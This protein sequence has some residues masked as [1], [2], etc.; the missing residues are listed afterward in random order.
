MENGREKALLELVTTTG[1]GPEIIEILYEFTN[2]DKEGIKKI[3]SSLHKNIMLVKANFDSPTIEKSGFF[4]FAYDVSRHEMLEKGFFAFR[5][6]QK[7]DLTQS[8]DEIRK[9][10]FEMKKEAKFNSRMWN[11][12]EREFNREGFLKELKRLIV[13]Y[14]DTM[15]F[16]RL[17]ETLLG[18]VLA[19]VFYHKNFSLGLQIEMLDPLLFFKPM[20]R[21]EES[22]KKEEKKQ[23]EREESKENENVIVTSKVYPVLDPINGKLVRDILSDEKVLFELRD[24]REAAS[25]IAEL[26]QK[27]YSGVLIGEIQSYSVLDE[28]TYKLN[29]FFAPGIRGECIV[30]NTVMLKL[31]EISEYERNSEAL[32]ENRNF[33]RVSYKSFITGI[34]IIIF[35]ILFFLFL[36]Q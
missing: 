15:K 7:L 35:I 24:E 33:I 8:W 3:L 23:F 18:K 2:G 29:V 27:K 25:Y 10:I 31:V 20:E 9:M 13:K 11:L 4:Y 6:F 34:I 16:Q 26:L 5:G 14:M 36:Y 1:Y 17:M 28:D 21:K 32:L 12:F 30:P 22:E 19:P